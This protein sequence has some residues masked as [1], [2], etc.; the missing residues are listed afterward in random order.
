MR[1]EREARELDAEGGRLGLDAVR[2]ADAGVS[3]CSRARRERVASSARRRPGS[4]PASRE[5]ERER[6]VE[7]VGGRQAEWIQRPPWPPTPPT[8]STNAATSWSVTCSRSRTASTV[9]VARS[10]SRE[11]PRC[12]P[13]PSPRA[14]RP[15]RARP[16]ATSPACAARSRR[17]PSPG[18]CSA[19]SR[20]EDA[21]RQHRGVPRVVHADPRDRHARR[22]LRDR[23]SASRPPATDVFEVSG[24]PITGRSVCA[25]TTPGSAA[26][27]PAPAMITR[28]PRMRAFLAYSATVVGVTVSAHHAD[29]EADPALL[30]LVAGPLHHRHVALRAHHDADGAARRTSSSSNSCSTAVSAPGISS[31][32]FTVCRYRFHRPRRDVAAHLRPSNSIRST[33]AYARSRASPGVPRARDAEDAAARGHELAVRARAVPAWN[34]STS[35]TSS[36]PV[37]TSPLDELS[38]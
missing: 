8:T 17:R 30:E 11:R 5:L 7:H 1:L 25:A 14:R 36:R 18:G 35:S 10:R 38:G 29:L 31:A 28:S 23:S 24:T 22:H 27:S 21:R 4:P 12:G 9:K 37:I 26:A 15:P 16:G 6:R 34:T 32:P 13:T 20:A 2:A 3:T 33:P 19:R